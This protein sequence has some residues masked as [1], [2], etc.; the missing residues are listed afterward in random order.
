MS[1]RKKRPEPA[2]AVTEPVAAAAAEEVVTKKQEEDALLYQL[3]LIRMKAVEDGKLAIAAQCCAHIAKLRELGGFA[4]PA[5]AQVN[6]TNNS[7]DLV[8][9]LDGDPEVVRARVTVACRKKHGEPLPLEEAT[10]FEELPTTP[11]TAKA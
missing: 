8:A 4:N 1:R 3:K 7:I 6:I 5:A 10:P 9:L 11:A 2:P